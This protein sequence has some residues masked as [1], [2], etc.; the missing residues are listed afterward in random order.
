MKIEIQ[1]FNSITVLKAKVS[2]PTLIITDSKKY[3]VA[4]HYDYDYEDDTVSSSFNAPIVVS[5][6]KDYINDVVA[7]ESRIKNLDTFDSPILANKLFDSS[8]INK[9]I[10]P[11]FYESLAQVLAFFH[12]FRES[13]TSE[14]IEKPAPDK[15][16]LSDNSIAYEFE[17]SE[18]V[19]LH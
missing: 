2:E 1:Q 8:R 12:N 19:L 4:L 14:P 17:E 16:I 3:W 9:E 13:E 6:G 18:E 15:S 7:K 11:Q 5:K 10:L